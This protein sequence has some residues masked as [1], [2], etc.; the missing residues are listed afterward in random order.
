MLH[1]LQIILYLVQ[2]IHQLFEF[3]GHPPEERGHLGVFEVFKFGDDEIT[4]LAGTDEINQAFQARAAQAGVIE[5]FRKHSGK[6]E[7][8]IANVFP[9]LALAIKGRR[10][11]IDGIGG[12]QHCAHIAQRFAIF[13]FDLVEVL[14]LAEFRQQVGNVGV[15]L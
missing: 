10:R 1:L 3:V 7:R 15:D 11:S 4:F 5:R 2:A 12:K 6:E 14:T 9:Y 8:I 13:V